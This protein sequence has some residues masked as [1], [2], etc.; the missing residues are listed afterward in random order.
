MDVQTSVKVTLTATL[1]TVMLEP[2]LIHSLK[3]GVRGAAMA[4]L[5]GE[6]TSAMVYL[7]LLYKR[8]FISIHKIFRMPPMRVLAPLI[9][10]GISLQIR[11]LCLNFTFLMVARVIQS[12]DDTGV[13]AA[14]HALAAQTFQLGG[15]VLGALGMAS[16]TMVPKAM[17]IQHTGGESTTSIAN[18]RPMI[19]R[20]ITWGS[21]LGVLIGLAQLILLPA[22]LRSSPLPQ[23]REAAR[24]P[25]LIAIA[26]QGVNGVVSV[27]EGC[28]MGTGHFT[29]L[30]INII[31]AA[32]GYLGALRVFPHRFGLTG[33]WISLSVFTLVRLIG[34]LVHLFGRMP[35]LQHESTKT[36]TEAALD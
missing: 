23:V 33:V 13:S 29:W 2:I 34:V 6:F 31:F 30:S 16:Q 4:C 15:I 5:A 18:A 11:S 14:A 27:G 19:K 28:M 22:I 9:R 12:L 3:I 36:K 7:K 35:S 8:N 20:L 1:V 26:F 10:G 17:I 32:L 21:T 25:A 24:V